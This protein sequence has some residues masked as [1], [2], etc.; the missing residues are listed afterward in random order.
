MS[1]HRAANFRLQAPLYV[2]TFAIGA[3]AGPSAD[4]R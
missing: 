4:A 1:A 3:A 2:K